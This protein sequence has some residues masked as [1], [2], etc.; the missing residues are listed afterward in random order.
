MTTI[1]Q[2]MECIWLMLKIAIG[3][4]SMFA[5][6]RIEPLLYWLRLESETRRQA[7]HEIGSLAIRTNRYK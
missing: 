4:M 5:L 2:Y 7:W 3:V 6:W 1:Q